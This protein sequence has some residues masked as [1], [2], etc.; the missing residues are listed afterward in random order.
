M[1]NWYEKV[2]I[3]NNLDCKHPNGRFF[4]TMATTPSPSKESSKED[5]NITALDSNALSD[6]EEDLTFSQLINRYNDD[7]MFSTSLLD[8]SSFENS[9][10]YQ[11]N[12]DDQH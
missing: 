10:S 1:Y 6:D 9:S 3:Q 2:Y 4:K 7:S 11:S 5:A 12:I 8:N